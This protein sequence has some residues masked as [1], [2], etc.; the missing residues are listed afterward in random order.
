[1]TE[2]NLINL[3]DAIISDN[4]SFLGVINIYGNLLGNILIPQSLVSSLLGSPSSPDPV[5]ASPATVDS[6]NNLSIN[7]QVTLA[8]QSGD[9]AVTNNNTG[10][11]ATS[12]NASTNL[13]IYNFTNSDIVG[14]NLLLVF[15][16]VSGNWVGLLLNEPAGSTSAALGGQ[17]Q[18]YVSQ[19]PTAITSTNTESINNLVNLSSTTGNATVSY[20][21]VGGN[22]TTGNA[23]ADANIVNIIGSDINL[24]GWLGILIINVFG[25][26]TGNLG[27]LP[28][29]SSVVT[30]TSSTPVTSGSAQN[31]SDMIIYV[32]Y[33][34]NTGPASSVT[35]VAPVIS[36]SNNP[37]SIHN[38]A[39][40][41]DS[42]STHG[43]KNSNNNDI[44]GIIGVVIG[45][46]LISLDRL[47]TFRQHKKLI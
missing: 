35:S 33:P 20:N 1:M 7:N 34:N 22:A 15:V 39:I 30:P 8:A 24:T 40:T 47:I 6:S 18:Q 12:G 37:P 16:N 3:L 11:N 44:I 43:I 32:F 19:I 4:Q 5:T 31:S 9:A 41:P 13:N 46:A 28:T 21:R 26:W 23:T 38:L 42:V 27:I 14:G 29:T 25:S 45:A 10:G 2:A 17:I 36:N